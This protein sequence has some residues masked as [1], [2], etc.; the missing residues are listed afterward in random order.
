MD[1]EHNEKDVSLADQLPSEEAR[2]ALA[3]AR[4]DPEAERDFALRYLPRIRAMLRAR[5]R[6][7]DLAADLVQDVM[8]ESICALRRGQLR[9]ASKLTA[10]VLAIARNVLNSHFGDTNRR[11][12]SLEFPDDLPDLRSFTEDLESE[13]R[14][15]LAMNAIAKLDPTDKIILHLTLVDGLKPG[16]IAEKLGLN[17]DVVRQRKVRATRRVVEFVADRSQIESSRHYTTGKTL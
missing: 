12:E 15:V 14:R 11:P 9:D 6:N 10:F 3:I 1:G 8:I 4:G 2:L 13:E 7:S 17:T 5:L 16:M